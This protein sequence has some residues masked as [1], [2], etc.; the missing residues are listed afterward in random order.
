MTGLYRHFLA[1][2]LSFAALTSAAAADR[3][4]VPGTFS[5][6]QDAL[7]AA[8]PGDVVEVADGRYFE[9]LVVPRSGLPGA[10]IVLRAAD[11][12]MPILDGTGVP[13]QFMILL[14]DV[15]HIRVIGLELVNNLGLTDGSGVRI[16]GAGTDLELRDLTI[17]AMRGDN[18]MG[19]TVYATR[20]TPVRDVRILDNTIFDCDAAPSEALTL[21]GNVDGF[22]IEGNT[23]RDIN[24]IGIDMI[25]GETSIQPDPALV[26]RNGV[27][28]GNTVLRANSIYGGGY[29]GGIYVDGGRDIVIE[30]N[31]VE[32]SD[33]GLEVGAENAGLVASGIIVRNNVLVRNERAG[34]VFGGYA[35]SVGRANDN[36]FRGNTLL[37]N[38]TV[39]VDGQGRYFVGGGIA[40]IWMQYGARNVV[41]NNLV[42]AGPENI[43]VGSFDTGS[44][45]DV[46]FD[47]NLYWS[48]DVAGAVFS[49]NGVGWEG[50]G[51]WRAA[52]GLDASSLVADPLLIDRAGGDA[53]IQRASPAVDAGDPSFVPAPLERDL[54]GRARL[55]GGTVDIGADEIELEG[56]LFADGFETGDLT[57]WSSEP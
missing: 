56:L 50:F 11:G 39:G 20:A 34:L 28:R 44:S 25:G 16:L 46:D 51:A 37:E 36:V 41:R 21:N 43:V 2:L 49:L 9:K 38:N 48:D 55:E 22:L 23:V 30:N 45:I 29:A 7:D 6:I 54:D 5:S 13:G 40:E 1:S 18:A 26:A 35:A 15:S 33:L 32:G 53:H 57:S 8:Q 19:I 42:V 52:T 24:N 14:Q 12:A 31:R 27:V 3:L 10:P 17:H 4:E 47:H